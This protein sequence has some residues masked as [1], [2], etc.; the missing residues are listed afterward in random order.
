MA[1][2]RLHIDKTLLRNIEKNSLIIME[3]QGKSK[4]KRQMT[5]ENEL[6]IKT[7]DSGIPLIIEDV[8][9]QHYFHQMIKVGGHGTFYQQLTAELHAY[10]GL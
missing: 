3:K 6:Q 8:P 1:V 9:N 7:M 4:R 10:P 5:I 2:L